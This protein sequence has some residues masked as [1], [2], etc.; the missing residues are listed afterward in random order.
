IKGPG[1]E[2]VE[3]GLH[4]I[5]R[6]VLSEGLV[7]VLRQ[8][9]H[10]EFYQPETMKMK[11]QFLGD[12]GQLQSMHLLGRKWDLLVMSDSS[13]HLKLFPRAPHVDGGSWKCNLVETGHTDM[14]TDVSVSPTGDW[15]LTGAKDCSLS[16]F[17]VQ[18]RN[19][20][21]RKR[22]EAAHSGHVSCLSFFKTCSKFVSVSDDLVMKIW[23]MVPE[24]EVQVEESVTQRA[25]HEG[26]VNCVAV[27]KNDHLLA[28]GS[29]DK[30][31][32]VWN[33]QLQVQGTLR[34]HKRG[35]WSV[36]FSPKERVIL[37]ASGDAD[38]RV[39]NLKDFSCLHTFEGHSQPVYTARFLCGGEEI[40]SCDGA[41]VVRLWNWAQ[42]KPITTSPPIEA[43]EGRV[44]ALCVTEN[45]TGFYTG[46]EDCAL[47]FYLDDVQLSDYTLDEVLGGIRSELR[48]DSTLVERLLEFAA[49]WNTR[50]KT[51]VIAQEVLSWVLANWSHHEIASWPS[52]VKT[53]EGM[54]PYTR[55]HHKRISRLEEQMAIVDYLQFLVN[56]FHMDVQ[57]A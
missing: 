47:S 49:Q 40:I 33:A 14:I 38:V 6:M 2:E 23:T 8:G 3:Y 24:D 52:A 19:L 22:V 30:C 51:C 34:G 12:L 25:V 57:P 43:H 53:V 41:G 21:L 39:W 18:K 26:P 7:T 28:T 16:L 20:K 55:R 37:S 10:M 1:G 56:D 5:T 48:E 32:K 11:H 4:S 42:K 17:S 46:G 50:A 27:S 54:I 13:M 31:V 36:C 15:L 9:D 45:E 35:V 44:L 29:R